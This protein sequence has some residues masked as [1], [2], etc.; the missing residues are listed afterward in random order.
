MYSN[1]REIPVLRSR[2]LLVVAPEAELRDT[3]TARPP[4]LGMATFENLDRLLPEVGAEVEDYV[5]KPCHITE[6]LARAQ[7]L[8]RTPPAC[9]GF[10]VFVPARARY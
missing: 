10:S 5:T 7:V 6:L 2:R 8:L 9:I 4:I 1:V 3:V